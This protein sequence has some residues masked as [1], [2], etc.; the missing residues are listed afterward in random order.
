MAARYCT[1]APDHEIE[2][3]YDIFA[4]LDQAVAP[5]RR[6]PG[7]DRRLQRGILDAA[8]RWHVESE[9]RH[10][11]AE[12]RPVDAEQ[13]FLGRTVIAERRRFLAER[14]FFVTQRRFFFT[15]RWL[16]RWHAI[17]GLG[18]VRRLFLAERQRG[19]WGIHPDRR[20]ARRRWCRW[21]DAG[22]GHPGSGF[23]GGR[24]AGCQQ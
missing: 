7:H 2:N 18:L 21:R 13:R 5:G 17:A 12:R 3:D 14:W 20:H 16:D 10:A 23:T 11:I 8:V 1:E 22:C 6:R 15:E 24:N 4:D 9:W 19:R